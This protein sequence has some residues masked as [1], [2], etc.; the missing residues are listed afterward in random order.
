MAPL[1]LGNDSAK[2]DDVHCARVPTICKTVS[3]MLA[4]TGKVKG[5]KHDGRPTMLDKAPGQVRATSNP[6]S[7]TT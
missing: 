7:I 2:W 4:V 1:A 6:G 5:V 3:E